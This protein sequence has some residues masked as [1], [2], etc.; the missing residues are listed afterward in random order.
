MKMNT[1]TNLYRVHEL[2]EYYLYTLADVVTYICDNYDLSVFSSYQ[3]FY[4]ENK[5][6]GI[7]QHNEYDLDI[8]PVLFG[9]YFVDGLTMEFCIETMK[10]SYEWA[11]TNAETLKILKRLFGEYVYPKYW[12][13]YMI[14]TT[15]T[16]EE[17]NH[18]FYLKMNQFYDGVITIL[19]QTWARYARLVKLYDAE[20]QYLMNSVEQTRELL[21]KYNDTPQESGQDDP[22]NEDSHLTDASKDVET[23]SNDL[24]TKMERLD[25]IERLWKNI[26]VEWAKEFERLFIAVGEYDYE[27]Q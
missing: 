1:R 3:Q 23:L 22:F 26:Y 14:K 12:N 8:L 24:M 17:D 5:G 18:Q 9:A 2:K 21:H 7:P 25:E 13:Q 27:E 10:W 19:N 6:N 20:S 4:L 16:R 15:K 11:S